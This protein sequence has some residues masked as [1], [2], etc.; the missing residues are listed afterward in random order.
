MNN[1]LPKIFRLIP[2]PTFINSAC[3]YTEP[4]YDEKYFSG[5]KFMKKLIVLC[6]FY[7]Q[8][9]MPLPGKA[10]IILFVTAMK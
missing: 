9:S 1:F 8:A 6:L 2:H 7:G 4:L 3:F 5:E 10:I